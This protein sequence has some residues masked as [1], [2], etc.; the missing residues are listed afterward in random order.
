MVV[1]NFDIEG[2]TVFEP[3]ANAPL[4]VDADAILSSSLAL[5]RFESVR[6]RHQQIVNAR[7]CIQLLKPHCR[8]L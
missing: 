6:P 7:C 1:D 3:K 5:Q 8:A 2:I 4:V